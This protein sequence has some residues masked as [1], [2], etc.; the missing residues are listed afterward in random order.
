[1]ENPP[2]E[3]VPNS[4]PP[5]SALPVVP[6]NIRERAMI[7]R[8]VFLAALLATATLTMTPAAASID[9]AYITAAVK[10]PAQPEADT[11]RDSNRK[12]AESLAFAGVKPGDTVLEL[13]AGGGYAPSLQN[14][15]A[16]RPCL[17]H[18]SGGPGSTQPG[19]RRWA[20]GA[21]CR[22]GLQQCHHSH[23]ADGPAGGARTG[24]YRLDL[25]QLS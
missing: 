19:R 4:D 20:Q 12:P 9:P 17:F 13:L 11:K 8:L 22:F 25:R 2:H 3:A 10:N 14:R 16:E 5:S 18:G 15:R 1:M 24:G 6:K 23:S 21:V 7:R